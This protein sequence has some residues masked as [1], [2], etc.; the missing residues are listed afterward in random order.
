MGLTEAEGRYMPGDS[1]TTLT[2]LTQEA[3]LAG[4]SSDCDRDCWP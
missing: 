3:I 2:F 1:K 4:A